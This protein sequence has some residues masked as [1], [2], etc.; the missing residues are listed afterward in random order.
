[1][2]RRPRDVDEMYVVHTTDKEREAIRAMG[3]EP[4]DTYAYCRPCWGVVSD[5]EK[6]AQLYRGL[7]QARF[8]QAGLSGIAEKQAQKAYDFLTTRAKPRS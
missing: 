4:Q 5:R 3:A 7:V 6:G 8:R 2:C 1:M